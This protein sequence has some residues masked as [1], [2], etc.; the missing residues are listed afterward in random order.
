[1][2]LCVDVCEYVVVCVPWKRPAGE[3]TSV[4]SSV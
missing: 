1:M 4:N 3:M 2:S